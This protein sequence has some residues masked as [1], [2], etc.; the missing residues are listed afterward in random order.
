MLFLAIFT[1]ILRQADDAD[2]TKKCVVQLI[3]SILKTSTEYHPPLIACL[4][5]S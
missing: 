1:A 2:D 5:V 4:M 3:E